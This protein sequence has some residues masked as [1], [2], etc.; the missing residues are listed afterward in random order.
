MSSIDRLELHLIIA[1][2]S[3]MIDLLRTAHL[4]SSNYK[5]GMQIYEHMIVH[6][7]VNATTVQRCARPV[8][9]ELPIRVIPSEN[10]KSS[11]EE[12]RML[13]ALQRLDELSIS[14]LPPREEAESFEKAVYILL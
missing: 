5:K 7:R 3:W 12:R 4:A 13:L 2:R 9:S 6:K 14:K 8:R 11:R 1:E 10:S